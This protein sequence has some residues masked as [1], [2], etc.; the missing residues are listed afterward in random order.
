MGN[1]SLLEEFQEKLGIRLNWQ[2]PFNKGRNI[3]NSGEYLPPN[4]S[5]L[6]GSS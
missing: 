3:L 5:A 2:E 1:S 4:F 6:A